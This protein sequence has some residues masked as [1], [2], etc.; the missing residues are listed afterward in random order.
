MID[1]YRCECGYIFAEVERD[2]AR[3]DFPCPRCGRPISRA[4]WEPRAKKDKLIE[5][6]REMIDFLTSVAGRSWLEFPDARA[7][8]AELCRKI[9]EAEGGTIDT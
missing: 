5:A 4:T 1:H 7:R 2:S 9:K 3:F 6:Q 8:Y